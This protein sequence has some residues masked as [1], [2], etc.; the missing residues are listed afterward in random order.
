MGILDDII[1]DLKPEIEIQGASHRRVFPGT[2]GWQQC[3][4]PLAEEGVNNI[5]TIPL[6]G[7]PPTTGLK[8]HFIIIKLNYR[9]N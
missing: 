5:I 3:Q 2:C 7:G 8:L 6:Q 4:L 1:G 9:A